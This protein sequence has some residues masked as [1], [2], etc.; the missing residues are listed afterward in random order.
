MDKLRIIPNLEIKEDFVVKGFQYEGVRKIDN[1]KI[2]AEKLYKSGADE[3]IFIDTVASLYKRNNLFDVIDYASKNIFIP[4]TVGGGIKNLK[5][6]YK[7]LRAGADKVCIN[8]HGIKNKQLIKDASR[9]FGSQCIVLFVQSKFIEQEY[10]CLTDNSR[11][12]SGL[13]VIDWIKE[14]EQLG[15]GEIL[16]SS[17]DRDGSN[18]G[19]DRKLIQKA[20]SIVKVPLIPHGGCGSL[21]DILELIKEN[22]SLNAF[23]SS[24]FIYE[25]NY[26]VKKIKNYLRKKKIN[27]RYE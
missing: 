10:F 7:L 12:N 1:P 24:S 9:E 3:I 2:I 13:K 25:L 15:V 11:E 19:Y 27:I 16:L 6:I 18:Q 21:N 5:D 17:V 20:C 14:A 23:S 26:D 8:T 4:V 22:K